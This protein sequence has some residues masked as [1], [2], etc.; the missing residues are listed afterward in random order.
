MI[1]A[2]VGRL[3][4]ASLHQ[5]IADTLP[6]RLDFY[7]EW[8]RS[9]GLR[10]GSIGPA[11][12]SAVLGFL[13]TEGGGYEAV[14]DRAGRLAAEWTVASMPAWRRRATGALP[15]GLRTRA[16]LRS[17]ARLVGEVCSTTR[18]AVELG[19][20]RARVVITGSLFCQARD[21]QGRPLCGFYAAMMVEMLARFDLSTRAN[22]EH[23]RM[24][25]G[26][27][28]VIVLEFATLGSSPAGDQA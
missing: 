6:Q 18:A 4:P 23:C 2:H 22:V 20:G 15:R 16:V 17:A 21:R 11:P 25:S 5:A 24:I 9:K 19:R 28:C 26:D 27:R 10:D 3:L 14:C 13:R 8:L 12:V 7:E 1:E